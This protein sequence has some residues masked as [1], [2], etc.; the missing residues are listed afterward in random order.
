[1]ALK[2]FRL[3]AVL[4]AFLFVTGCT[5]SQDATGTNSISAPAAEK[6]SIPPGAPL[7]ATPRLKI[8]EKNKS[9]YAL[10]VCSCNS[11]A[12]TL[13]A[14]INIKE[15][16]SEIWSDKNTSPLTGFSVPSDSCFCVTLFEVKRK[17]TKPIVLEIAWR[18]GPEKG[19]ERFVVSPKQGHAS[20][21]TQNRDVKR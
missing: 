13:E 18:A 1:M 11:K 3:L 10:E 20:P 15:G 12:D 2:H 21:T 7:I 8:T 6:S 14:T 5:P 4:S 17:R 9:I 16:G 19:L